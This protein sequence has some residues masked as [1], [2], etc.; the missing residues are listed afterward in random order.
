MK[1]FRQH[2]VEQLIEWRNNN[3]NLILLLD[4]ND[5]MA[6][7]PLSRLLQDP[8]LDMVDAIQLR[9]QNPDPHTFV[10]GSRQID[11]A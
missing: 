4:D 6:S 2:L 5:N 9:Y 3:E 7:G 11:S 8:D 10:R 1:L